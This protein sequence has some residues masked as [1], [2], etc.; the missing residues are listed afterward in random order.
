MGN[1]GIWT[2]REKNE[3]AQGIVLQEVDAL[4]LLAAVDTL[5]LSLTAL[6]S[7]LC[8]GQEGGVLHRL[9]AAAAVRQGRPRSPQSVI[10]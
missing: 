3:E 2:N 1:K 10:S 6:G 4:I 7:R 5:Y 9:P 8:P